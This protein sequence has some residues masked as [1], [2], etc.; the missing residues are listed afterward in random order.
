MDFS[1]AFDKI[2]QSSHL[3]TPEDRHWW[4]DSL[5]DH[6]IPDWSNEMCSGWWWKFRHSISHEWVLTS[7]APSCSWF[8]LMTSPQAFL[9]LLVCLQY[10]HVPDHQLHGW[11]GEVTGWPD[12]TGGLREGIAHELHQEK[13]SV[14]GLTKKRTKIQTDY[15]LNGHTLVEVESAK[16]LG[17]MISNDMTWNAHIE[18]A[19]AKGNNRLGFLKR[20]L[21]VKSLEVKEKAYKHPYIQHFNTAVAS[22]TPQPRPSHKELRWCRAGKQDG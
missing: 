20:K 16:Y 18:K 4:I 9:H 14:L 12:Q 13:C 11:W 5:V 10:Y 21:K 7:L 15:K 3:H 19:V 17:L 8:A 6:I 1:K 2:S 22:G